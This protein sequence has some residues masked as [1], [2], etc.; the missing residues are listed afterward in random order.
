MEKRNTPKEQDKPSDRL[1]A[2]DA[3]KISEENALDLA[4][5]IDDTMGRRFGLFEQQARLARQ[6]PHSL[7]LLF[8][9]LRGGVVDDETGSLLIGLESK[10]FSNEPN[11][12]IGFVSG[13]R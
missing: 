4:L 2:S 5:D 1:E 7:I 9:Q 10:F 13:R 6:Q 8:Q 12:D 3:N 11:T